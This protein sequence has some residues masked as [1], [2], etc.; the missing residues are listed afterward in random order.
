MSFLEELQEG[1]K[2]IS[3]AATNPWFIAATISFWLQV[4]VMTL[5]AAKRHD[6]YFLEAFR[7]LLEGELVKKDW[8]LGIC[9][10][11]NITVTFGILVFGLAG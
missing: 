9:V 4:A 10:V 5:V 1:G 2:E 3:T 7:K 11:V 6:L 8:V